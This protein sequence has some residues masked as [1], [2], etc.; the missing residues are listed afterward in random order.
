MHLARLVRIDVGDITD[1]LG[2]GAGQQYVI[3]QEQDQGHGQGAQHTRDHD[4][5]RAVQE[6]TA[7]GYGV[8]RQSQV[9]VIFVV[10]LAP[11]QFDAV[12]LVGTEQP[13]GQGTIGIVDQRPFPAGQGRFIRVPDRGETYGI[14]LEQA[15]DHLH[16]HFPIQTVDRLGGGITGHGQNLLGR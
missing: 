1:D 2:Q 6:F 4:D 9:A 7:I 12:L 3:D 14:V 13:V 15:F 10:G 16:G 11:V 5:H 8:Q